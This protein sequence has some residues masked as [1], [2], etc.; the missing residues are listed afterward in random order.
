M[1]WHTHTHWRNYVYKFM[2]RMDVQRA[3][4]V[5]CVVWRA[6]NFCTFSTSFGT[7]I[8]ALAFF[9]A[10]FRCSVKQNEVHFVRF[11]RHSL[12][13][14]VIDD[15]MD[16]YEKRNHSYINFNNVQNLSRDEELHLQRINQRP[17]LFAAFV[18]IR[19]T[20]FA[21]LWRLIDSVAYRINTKTIRIHFELA[22]YTLDRI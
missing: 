8:Y 6:N 5:Q 2:H 22:I 10:H 9:V 18:L 13:G 3:H 17:I 14:I 11:V 4:K 1:A 15:K 16:E 21:V 7:P 19:L 12:H 20:Q